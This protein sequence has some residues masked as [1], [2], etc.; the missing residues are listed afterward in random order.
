MRLKCYWLTDDK[1]DKDNILLNG[2]DMVQ[3][4]TL[5]NQPETSSM[6]EKPLK[7]KM[8]KS[9]ESSLSTSF[10]STPMPSHSGSYF[11]SEHASAETNP[12]SPFKQNESITIPRTSSTTP[13]PTQQAIML[14]K[15][16][17]P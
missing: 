1:E 14:L 15:Y 5:G 10:F 3:A 2:K 11:I 9:L 16:I 4:I 17:N 13:S 6:Q 7:Q 12:A 8:T